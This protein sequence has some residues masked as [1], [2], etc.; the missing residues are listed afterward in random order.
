MWYSTNLMMAPFFI[1]ELSPWPSDYEAP[2]QPG[3]TYS[4]TWL[5][6]WQFL[7][8]FQSEVMWWDT[9]QVLP[10]LSAVSNYCN[11]DFF[12]GGMWRCVGVIAGWPFCPLSSEFFFFSITVY[13]YF[14][15][16]LLLHSFIWYSTKIQLWDGLWTLYCSH[17]PFGLVFGTHWLYNI[18]WGW[19]YGVLQ[20]MI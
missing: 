4:V 8:C 7:S 1:L 16:R 9:L 10:I 6:P 5:L 14:C 3:P 13:I 2:S 15:I 12:I 11:T 18:A 20:I 19:V 17:G